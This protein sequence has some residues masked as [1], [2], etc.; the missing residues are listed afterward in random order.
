MAD[1][2]SIAGLAAGVI[3]LGLQVVGGLSNYLNSVEGRT[4]ELDSAKQEARNMKGLLLTI[5]DLLPQL[6][7]SW[8]ASATMIEQHIKCC[9]TE[10]SALYV[11]L[12]DLTQP[13]LS[14]SGIR[15]KL[16]D[17]K[18]KLIYPF[19]RSRVI[20]LEDRLSKVNSALQTALEV[21]GLNVSITSA[22]KIDEVHDISI[23]STD[24]INEVHGASIASLDEIRQLRVASV[25]SETKIDQVYDEIC[26]L[27]DTVVLMFQSQA[28][29][30]QST[31]VC[32]PSAVSSKGTGGSVSREVRIPLDSMEAAKSLASKPSLLSTSIKALEGFDASRACL[33]RSS[34]K[35]SHQ[36][37]RWGC[38]LFSSE[39]SSTRKHL[40]S[41]PFSQIDSQTWATKYSIGY[42][43]LRKLVRS[44]F[45]LSFVNKYGAGGESISRGF[46][47]YPTVDA[48]TAPAFRIMNLTGILVMCSKK[49]HVDERLIAEALRYC[50]DSIVELYRQKKASPKD[51]TLD[52]WSLLH[53]MARGFILWGSEDKGDP[54]VETIFSSTMNLIASGVPAATYHG[55]CEKV[56][57]SGGLLLQ[58]RGNNTLR[59][60][61]KLLLPV[62]PDVPLITPDSWLIGRRMGNTDVFLQD[63][64]LA[65]ATGCGPLSLAARAGNEELVQHL[66]KQHPQSLEEV[67][68]FGVTPLHLAIKHPSCLR[69]ILDAGGLSMLEANDF[70]DCTPLGWASFLG[71]RTST[72]ILLSSGG[73][74]HLEYIRRGHESCIDDLLTA[75]KQRRHE[76]KL[77]ALEN[78]TESEARYFGL[79][80]NQVLDRHAFQVQGL[81]QRMGVHVPSSLHIIDLLG[82]KSIYH[83]STFSISTWDKLWALGFCDVNTPGLALLNYSCLFK[84]VRWLIEHGADYWTP[85]R[86]RINFRS[87]QQITATPAH[88]LLAR[89]MNWKV[90]DLKAKSRVVQKL[91]EVQV[92]DTCSCPCFVG[93]CTPLKALFDGLF[94]RWALP[95]PQESTRYITS[96]QTLDNTL[97][98]EDFIAVLRRMTFDA[99]QLTHTCCDFTRNMSYPRSYP[100]SLRT[101]EEVIEIYSE[102]SA[103]LAVFANLLIEFESIAYE[104][105]NGVPLIVSNPEEF[106]MHRWLHRIMETLDSLDGDDLTEEEKSAAEAIGVVWGRPPLPARPVVR[107]WKDMGDEYD[108]M[109]SS[110]EWVMK[111]VQEIMNER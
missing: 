85:I 31:E 16:E 50:Y 60:L 21:T 76:L 26:R 18:K 96:F 42:K 102:E 12:S 63:L 71:Y 53:G 81:L 49:K 95:S 61:A 20:N 54:V 88:F 58:S 56:T 24:K 55:G 83:A 17:Q 22:T 111:K 105:Q 66:L 106:W 86:E 74:I 33:C 7:S 28:T 45:V 47:Y 32:L 38:F 84:R 11:L 15:L 68:Q 2:L 82:A 36:Q 91:F 6:Q 39:V 107:P 72:Q 43:G 5:Q 99:L 80:E 89:V 29:Q 75:L 14:Y 101:P 104:D 90:G 93:G 110:P 51:S 77:L 35:I 13:H 97:N 10:L 4:D 108:L 109:L 59:E 25:S 19:N 64:R 44:G 9:D 30:I 48:R 34:R 41:C 79:H 3:S 69:L 40:P 67:T 8:P 103:L 23:T 37:S 92:R 100:A 65:E 94:H 52:G 46:T 57:P 1:P 78:L 98:E 62:E 70:W 87:A 73:H 27:R